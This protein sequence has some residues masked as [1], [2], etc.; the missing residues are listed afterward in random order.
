MT[1][2]ARDAGAGPPGTGSPGTGTGP[3]ELPVAR[4]DPFSPPAGLGQLRD[5][6]PLRRLRYPDGHVGWLVTS[7]DLARAILA[8]ARFSARSE[9]KRAPVARPGLDSFV[10]TEAR[11]GWF[12]DMDGQRHYRYRRLLAREFTVRRMAA[13]EPRV[14]RI[15]EDCLDRLAAAAPPADLV[16]AFALPVPSAVI[17]ELLGVPY[18]DR[19]RFQHDSEI[20][21]RLDATAEVARDALAR[22]TDYMLGLVAHQRARP[23]DGLVSRLASG[24][25]LT[26]AE[27]AGTCVLLLTAGHE[28]LAGMLGLST[29][30][31]LQRPGQL[32]RLLAGPVAARAATEELLRYLTTFQFGVPR[33]AQEDA[34]VGGQLIRAGET[35]TISLPAANR[36]PGR[37]GA[38]DE[39]DLGREARGHLAFGHGMH[40]CVGQHLARAELRIA[41]PALFRRLPGLRL[42]VP[43]AQV[44]LR[45]D[46]AFYGVH[47][48]PVAW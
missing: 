1:S 29:L 39:L 20:F 43:A 21:F 11:P 40:Q 34:E 37:F 35:V 6:A 10:G 3:V 32:A 22:L 23:A 7:Y 45:S 27:I 48:L 46:A 19:A 5:Q 42:A 2:P 30:L 13:L 38:P 14:E 8:D 47:R 17:C 26:D 28:T 44:P 15:V 33:G 12:V 4:S 9:L 16:A 41:L 36:D 24:G 31:L 25:E 18:A